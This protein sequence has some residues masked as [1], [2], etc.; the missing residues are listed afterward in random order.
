VVHRARS[1][2]ANDFTPNH[3]RNFLIAR[4]HPA[5]FVPEAGFQR[6][7]LLHL[8]RVLVSTPLH[9]LPE[10][11]PLFDCPNR[12]DSFW[13]D[14]GLGSFRDG[15]QPTLAGISFHILA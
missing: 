15:L 2:F 3:H 13:I 11:V 6:S 10:D 14:E 1:S 7:H 12:I 5:A 9:S 4:P 8:P